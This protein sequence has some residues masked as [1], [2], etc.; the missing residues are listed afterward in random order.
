MPNLR[1]SKCVAFRQWEESE[2][3]TGLQN[4][5]S[6]KDRNAF[7][8]ACKKG[9]LTMLRFLNSLEENNSKHA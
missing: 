5:P 7:G 6:W 1:F 9:A 3:F 8:K 4:I 2:L